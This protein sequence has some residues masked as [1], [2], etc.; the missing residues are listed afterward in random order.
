[1]DE[2][3]AVQFILNDAA[4]IIFVVKSL[5]FVKDELVFYKIRCNV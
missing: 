3:Q 1:M 5:V 4:R 2:E